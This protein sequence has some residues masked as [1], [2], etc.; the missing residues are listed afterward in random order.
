MA[1]EM[2]Q[3]K[4]DASTDRY[5]A[6]GVDDGTTEDS[7]N[8]FELDA[9][10]MLEWGS[11]SATPD[12]N[13]YR[14]AADTLKT[15]DSLVVGA[16]ATIGTTLGVTGQITVTG[17]VKETITTE[18]TAAS[19]LANYGVSV[20]GSSGAV[21]YTLAAPVA[22]IRKSIVVTGAS[23]LIKS[24]TSNGA[25]MGSTANNKA[26]IDNAGGSLHLLGMSTSMWAIIGKSTFCTMSTA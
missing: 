1:D 12:T 20:L 14:S 8:R 17:G 22:G 24:I 11:G 16:A 25:T 4:M 3:L 18:S 6:L 21:D 23:T 5:L 13:L 19:T 15:D 26:S 2:V 7:Y 10:G 9:A